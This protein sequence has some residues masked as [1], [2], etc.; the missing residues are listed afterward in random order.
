[1]VTRNAPNRKLTLKDKPLVDSED[2][3]VIKIGAARLAY[4]LGISS[5]HAKVTSGPAKNKKNRPFW[6]ID[7]SGHNTTLTTLFI[8]P[9]P[10]DQQPF[11]ERK[12]VLTI[13]TPVD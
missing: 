12:I 11:L 9:H 10:V 6:N 7:V 2:H 3:S 4:A 5:P 8:V 13:Q 1:M